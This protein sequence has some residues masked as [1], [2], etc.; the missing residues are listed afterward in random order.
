MARCIPFDN[1]DKRALRA[2]DDFTFSNDGE[3]ARVVGEMEVMVVRPDGSDQFWLT[4]TF[5]SGEELDVRIR[6]IQLLEQLNIEA[7]DS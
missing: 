2:L 5:P 7:D 3:T 6:R 4:I 1:Q